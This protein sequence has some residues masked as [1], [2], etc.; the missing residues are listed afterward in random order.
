MWRNVYHRSNKR[1]VMN[2]FAKT[3]PV[4]LGTLTEDKPIRR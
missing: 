2:A 3:K 4:E 1:L